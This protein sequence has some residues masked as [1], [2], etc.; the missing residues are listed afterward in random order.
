MIFAQMV[1]NSLPLKERKV[2]YHAGHE[3]LIEVDVWSFIFWGII[4][5]N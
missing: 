4:P 3:V 1:K 2:Y 5:V